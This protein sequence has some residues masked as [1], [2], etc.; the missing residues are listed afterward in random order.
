MSNQKV[1]ENKSEMITISKSELEAL[2]S[3]RDR[4]NEKAER[5]RETASQLAKQADKY[6]VVAYVL[7]RGARKGIKQLN[8]V[9]P[10]SLR[11]WLQHG[12]IMYEVLEPK[13]KKE[14]NSSKWNTRKLTDKEMSVFLALF[15]QLTGLNEERVKALIH[16]TPTFASEDAESQVI[17]ATQ[18]KPASLEF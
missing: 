10:L 2:I 13:S 8:I 12:V 18:V 5:E 11:C 14:A 9:S 15:F 1:V 7:D 6:S 17:P 4:A 3:Q 16:A